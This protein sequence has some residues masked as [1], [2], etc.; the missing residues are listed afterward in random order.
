MAL[1]DQ[2]VVVLGGSSGMGLATA[3]AAAAAGAA[4]TIA[5]SGKERLDAALAELPD[6]CEGFVTDVR[7]EANVAALFEHVGSLDH[8]VYTAGDAPR[9]LPLADLSLADAQSGF[10]VRYWGAVSAVKHAA[11]RIRPGGSIVLT[12]GIIGLRPTPG[13][14]LAAGA[15]GAVE[16]LARGLAVDLAPVRVNTVRPGPVH[17]PMWDSLP[18]PQLDAMIAAFTERTLTKSVGEADQVAATNVYL[19]ENS[20]V[21]GAVITVDGG[22]VL[23]GS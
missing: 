5:A 12:S 16:G 8:L 20:F 19:M 23:T 11:P 15:V 6:S 17:T 21:T 13:A 18:Q 2:R 10:D 4:V 1:L 7:D 14:A 22:F 9:Q 3:R